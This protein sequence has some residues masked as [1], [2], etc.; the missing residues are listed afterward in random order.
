[1][2]EDD[3]PLKCLNRI[4]DAALALDW[5]KLYNNAEYFWNEGWSITNI[6]E[7][8]ISDPTHKALIVCP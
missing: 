6:P 1:M 4:T 7:P 5:I 8:E 2:P 3:T